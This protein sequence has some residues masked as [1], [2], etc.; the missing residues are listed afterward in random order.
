M[1]PAPPPPPPL[2]LIRLVPLKPLT[3]G[4]ATAPA[5]PSPPS[6]PVE[7]PSTPR[8]IGR[9]W[10]VAGVG[11]I[12]FLAAFSATSAI[13]QNQ[14]ATCDHRRLEDGHATCA[15]ATSNRC[16]RW[17]AAGAEAVLRLRA[18][19][20]SGDF[21]DYWQ[22]HLEKER[23]RTHNS[24]YADGD[25]PNPASAFAATPEA[26]QVIETPPVEPC[27]ERAAPF[28]FGAALSGHSSQGDSDHLTSRR[29]GSGGGSGLGAI[30][31]GLVVV[32]MPGDAIRLRSIR[33]DRP[34][35]L[36]KII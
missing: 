22:F 9:E 5:D 8:G 28:P 29:C 7:D 12:A 19:R 36:I 20:T 30:A 33:K 24:R 34:A 6:P 18:L 14:A 27:H 11:D 26:C 31:A 35:Q 4:P 16:A 3:P 25:V 13:G 21:D 32:I 1:S 17:S 23:E 15:A 10:V 2:E